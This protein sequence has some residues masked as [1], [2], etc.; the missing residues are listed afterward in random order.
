MTIAGNKNRKPKSGLRAKAWNCYEACEYVGTCKKGLRNHLNTEHRKEMEAATSAAS[1]LAVGLGF[2]ICVNCHKVGRTTTDGEVRAH[3]CKKDEEQAAPTTPSKTAKTPKGTLKRR[4]SQRT[5]TPTK[6]PKKA[7]ATMPRSE[8]ATSHTPA[9]GIVTRSG[10]KVK[11]TLAFEEQHAEAAPTVDSPV[12]EVE[13]SDTEAPPAPAAPYK[14]ESHKSFPRW[15]TDTI[16]RFGVL[17]RALAENN[18]GP[19]SAEA[20]IALG[21]LINS[22]WSAT[23]NREFVMKTPTEDESPAVLNEL[24]KQ[25][26]QLRVTANGKAWA[27]N[28]ALKSGRMRDATRVYSSLGL[29]DPSIREIED[30]IRSKYPQSYDNGQINAD[31]LDLWKHGP[32]PLAFSTDEIE[33]AIRRKRK[34]TGADQ[35]GWSFDDLKDIAKT[36]GSYEF[37]VPITNAIVRGHFNHDPRAVQLLTHLRGIPLAKDVDKTGV[38]PIGIGVIFHTL[39]KSL[40]NQRHMLE[41]KERAGPYQHAVGDPCGTDICGRFAVVAAANRLPFGWADGMNAFGTA[42]RAQIYNALNIDGIAPVNALSYGNVPK[43]SFGVIDIL[44]P[45]GAIQGCAVAQPAFCG[46]QETAIGA[47]LAKQ[48]NPAVGVERVAHSLFAD[49]NGMCTPKLGNLLLAHSQVAEE[50]EEKL[51]VVRGALHV[52]YADMTDE[53]REAALS[54]GCI[55]EDGGTVFVGTPVGSDEF[56]KAYAMESAQKLINLLN[57]AETVASKNG[58]QG[59]QLVLHWLRHTI[60]STFNHTLRNVPPDLVHDA[61]TAL[62]K[63]VVSSIMRITGLGQIFSAA[64]ESVQLDARD[65]LNLPISEGGVGFM[66]QNDTAP[67]AFVGAWASSLCKVVGEFGHKIP[68]PEPDDPIPPFLVHYV[69]AL[70]YLKPSIPSTLY[71]ELHYRKLWAAPR[72]GMQKVLSEY[73]NKEKRQ[74]LWSSVPTGDSLDDRANRISAL[75]HSTPES[76]AWLTANPTY[77]QCAMGNG[78]YSDALRRRLR[79]PLPGINTGQQCAACASLIEPLGMHA[80]CCMKIEKSNR[81]KIVQEAAAQCMREGSAAVV[82]NPQV[83]TFYPKKP[84]APEEDVDNTKSQGDI[85]ITLKNINAGGNLTIVDFTVVAPVKGTAVPYEKAGDLAD[86]KEK[87]KVAQYE[88]R[89]DIPKGRIIGFA[90]ETTGPWGPAAKR[91]MWSVAEACGGTPDLI[92]R[93]YRR[94][95]EVISVALQVALYNSHRRFLAVCIKAPVIGG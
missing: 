10:R 74:L 47:T 12:A 61:A 8:S 48:S 91:L 60:G 27:A 68:C 51:H 64:P 73:V 95:T 31:A 78:A 25:L 30:I 40:L 79:L 11:R 39:A 36:T 90:I 37:M 34:G 43:V 23:R 65:I 28:R 86:L 83:E 93:R 15:G 81:H 9:D 3:K 55:I 80:N 70:D 19:A 7:P 4:R 2:A 50:L 54:A 29:C 46:A 88:A 41:L 33:K 63:A 5:T 72:Q 6:K 62:D 58:D 57:F 76:S 49:D 16:G 17:N 71:D 75:G 53:E 18:E 87:S 32:T 56:V 45:E 38:R 82:R 77:K 89:Y 13:Q 21:N 26:Q 67:A 1:I 44:Q 92:A 59:M 14:A 94:Y 35:S 85:G 42:G 20:C 24:Q 69:N 66:S 52:Y 22:S 84:E